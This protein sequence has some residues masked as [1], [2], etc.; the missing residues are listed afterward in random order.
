MLRLLLR[1]LWPAIVAV[2]LLVAIAGPFV[3]IYSGAYDVAATR[4]HTRPCTGP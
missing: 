2:A 3:F 4:Q 1:A